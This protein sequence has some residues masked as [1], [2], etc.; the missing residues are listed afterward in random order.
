MILLNPCYNLKP[1]YQFKITQQTLEKKY[2][3]VLFDQKKNNN[4]TKMALRAVSLSCSSACVHFVE[5]PHNLAIIIYSSSTDP[6]TGYTY[7]YQ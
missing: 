2:Q 6:P 3:S 7:E 1:S 5:L 4:L